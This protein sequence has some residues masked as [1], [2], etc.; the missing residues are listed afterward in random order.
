MSPLEPLGK[1]PCLLLAASQGC[2]LS[3]ADGRTPP[4]SAFLVTLPP[5][6]CVPSKDTSLGLGPIQ[7]IQGDL[8]SRSLTLWCLQRPSSQIRSHLQ[9]LG[10]RM[11]TC[12]L[13][14]GVQRPASHGET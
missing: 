14:A 1:S 11:G 8:I 3:L 6:H 2:L 7:I 12:L 5:P 10:T 9:I 13:Q 4:I